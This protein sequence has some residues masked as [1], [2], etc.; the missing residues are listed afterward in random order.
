M[1]AENRYITHNK[2]GEGTYATVYRGQ[3]RTTGETVA[4]KE[5]NLDPDEGA[6]STA[7]REISLMKELKHPN[8]VKLLDVVHTE[9][10]LTLVFE[11]MEQDLKKY[12]DTRGQNGVLEPATIKK[13][14]YQLISGLAYCHDSRVLHRDLKPQN[15][16]IDAH[17]NLKL[18][19][20]GLARAF[21]IPVAS[22]S[23]EV[24]T[25]WY[26]AP[27]VLLGARNYST[28]IDLWSVG[29]IMAELY[30]GRPLFPGVNND[31][32]LLRI[33]RLLGT[34][35]EQ[36]WPGVSQYSNW[37]GNYPFYPPT[38]IG[39]AIPTHNDY[40]ALDLIFRFLQYQPQ[41]RLS[42]QDALDHPYF[43]G[44]IL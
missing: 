41:G 8:I 19:D 40:T 39:Q 32:Q 9:T 2:L 20:F 6:P 23:N 44:V 37:H 1:S 30:L 31:D 21:G 16:L 12:Q 4:L 17:H 3:N 14:M 25:L 43:Q 28:A 36:N 13:F 29:C 34:P 42:A 26:R 18:G 38:P 10:R 15:L 5:I 11:Y 7:I 24:V 33:F 22:F 35:S 27:D